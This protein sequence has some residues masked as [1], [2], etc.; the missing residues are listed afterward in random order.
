MVKILNFFIIR[1]RN[2]KFWLYKDYGALI[3]Y[4]L[5]KIGLG[6]PFGPPGPRKGK[7]LKFLFLNVGPSKFYCILILVP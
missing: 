1:P 3:T 4:Q 7:I 2:V 5:K 6:P